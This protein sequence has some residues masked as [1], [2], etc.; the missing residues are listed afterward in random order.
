MGPSAKS[1]F[2]NPALRPSQS[3]VD[4]FNSLTSDIC[5][6]YIGQMY[7][8]DKHETGPSHPFTSITVRVPKGSEAAFEKLVGA[9]RDAVLAMTGPSQDSSILAAH[10][11][12]ELSAATEW[13]KSLTA[14]E[15]AIW[16]LWI[17]SAPELVPA[18]RIVSELGLNGTN[19]IKGH[20][21]HMASKGQEVGFQVGWQS[22]KVDPITHERLYG[23][24]DFGTGE[25]PVD[26]RPI[27]GLEYANLLQKARAAAETQS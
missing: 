24:R 23:V 14:N 13:W 4:A 7:T 16:N 3:A 22:H 27:T 12:F 8:V 26:T 20:I 25:N 18:S 1:G 2:P 6:I 19:S 10:S 5:H 21:N 17:D 9:W 15:R 11:P